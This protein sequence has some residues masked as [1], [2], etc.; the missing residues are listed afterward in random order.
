VDR[1]VVVD[2]GVL[3]V[4]P[5]PLVRPPLELAHP[6]PGDPELASEGP[7]RPAVVGE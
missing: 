4:F 5:D 2:A 1:L 6:V 7:E 3:E